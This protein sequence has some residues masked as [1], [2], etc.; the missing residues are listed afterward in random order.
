MRIRIWPVLNILR[1][2][3]AL[4][5]GLLVGCS[6]GVS[7][8]I[9]GLVLGFLVDELLGQLR[10]E[11]QVRSYLE[12]PGGSRFYEPA[13]GIAAYC[14]LALLIRSRSVYTDAEGTALQDTE[15]LLLQ[16]I[17]HSAINCFY[18]PDKET[19]LVESFCRQALCRIGKLNPDLLAESLAA[20]RKE[21][22]D[23]QRIAEH[24]AK[25]AEGSTALAVLHRI[26]KILCPLTV[27]E[28]STAWHIL[29]L[30]QGASTEE[31]KRT[32]RRLAA[33]F[34]PDL[35]GNLDEEK[36]QHAS[37]AFIKIRAAYRELLSLR[38]DAAVPRQQ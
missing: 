9:I 25:L 20:R 7:G 27:Q 18:C 36:R 29:G 32:F 24:L 3:S 28:A 13:E 19:A 2:H 10:T 26:Q 38:H 21:Y 1:N 17:L 12:N 4:L 15:A 23:I 35:L 6:A 33:Q 37:E 31:I 34:H 14:A 22:G 8:I 11:H 30:D 5:A 16:N